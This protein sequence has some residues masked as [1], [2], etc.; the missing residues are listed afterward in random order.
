MS[1][2]GFGHLEENVLIC[3]IA[4]KM[5]VINCIFFPL[6]CSYVLKKNA[7]NTHIFPTN[8]YTLPNFWSSD[9]RTK[10]ALQS[11]RQLCLDMGSTNNY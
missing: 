3:P 5:Y 11:K 7:N 2:I 4:L 10:R 8:G 9:R 6:K 1:N